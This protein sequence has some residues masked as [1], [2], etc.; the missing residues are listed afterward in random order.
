[1]CVILN[2]VKQSHLRRNTESVY[3]W[4][5][6]PYTYPKPLPETKQK[7]EHAK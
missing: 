7:E 5:E 2:L 3:L 6:W 1:M 4:W